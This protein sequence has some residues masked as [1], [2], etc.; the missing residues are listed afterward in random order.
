[1]TDIVKRLR[2]FCK[3]PKPGDRIPNDPVFAGAADLKEAAAEIEQL[4]GALRNIRDLC[5]DSD[6][7]HRET[8]EYIEGLVINALPQEDGR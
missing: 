7:P 2:K 5:Y 8:F 4:R 3:R 6:L 1:M